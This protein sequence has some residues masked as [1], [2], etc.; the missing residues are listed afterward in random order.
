MDS[1]SSD[2]GKRTDAAAFLCDR[3]PGVG[4]LLLVCR[5]RCGGAFGSE[6]AAKTGVAVLEDRPFAAIIA[7][8][9]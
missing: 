9:V 5:V 8:P 6:T 3:L 7:D 1:S 2:A 4:S